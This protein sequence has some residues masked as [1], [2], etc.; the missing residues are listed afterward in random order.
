MVSR[1]SGWVEIATDLRFG[2]C[3]FRGI[4]CFDHGSCVAQGR[5]VDSRISRALLFGGQCA[6]AFLDVFERA[7]IPCLEVVGILQ[8]DDVLA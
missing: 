4:I 2:G 8:G 5:F 3:T 7:Q 1:R 6:D